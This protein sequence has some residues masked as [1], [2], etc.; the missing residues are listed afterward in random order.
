MKRFSRIM[1]LSSTA[2]AMLSTPAL[3]QTAPATAVDSNEIIVTAQRRSE[4]LL[5]IPL[6]ISATKG[7][8]LVKTGIADITSLRFTTP[9]FMTLSGVGYTQ[10]YIRG[11]GNRILTGADPSVAT[12][13]DDVPRVYGAFVDNLANVE[14]VEV[15]KGAQGGLYGRNATGGV[16]NVIT[17]QPS[18]DGVI[19]EGRVSYGEKKTF[20]ANVFV[21]IPLNE[22]VAL[23]LVGSRES[24]DDYVK[25]VAT[26]NPYQSYAALS[27]SQAA[28]LGDTG[29]R[30]YLLANPNLVTALDK[31]SKVSRL[32][33]LDRWYGAGKLGLQG[34]GFTVTLGGDYSQDSSSNGN[35]W[36]NENPAKTNAVYRSL[37]SSTGNLLFG[38]IAPTGP[39]I[40]PAAYVS[41]QQGKFESVA[42]IEH[43][44]LIK[45]YG[46]SARAD[47]D[48]PA[49]TLSSITA[50][51]W[52]NSEFMGDVGISNV[53]LAGFVS[54]AKRRFAYQELR[55]V[56]TNDGPFIWLGGAT[57]FHEKIDY[58]LTSVV[59]GQSFSPTRSS[60]NTTA[61]S[62]Y[63]QGEYSVTDR[64]KLIASLRYISE[65]KGGSYPAQTVTIFNFAPDMPVA[66]RPMGLVPGVAVP[67]ASVSDKLN[68]L[69]PSATISYGLEDG[70][71]IYLRW[72][73]GL[74][75]GGVNP[76][77]HPAQTLGTVNAFKPEEVDTY[78]AGYKTILFDR[79][80]QL[81]TAI[82]YNDFRN[83]QVTR[84]G[85]TGLSLVMLNAGKAKTYGGEISVDW[86]VSPIFN[87]SAN[88]GYLHARYTDFRFA[89]IPELQVRAFDLSGNTM[90][91]APKWQ[92]SVTANVD[93]PISAN[94]NVAGTL[95]YS[96][97]SKYF[98]TDD[99]NPIVAQK[100]YSLVNA[101]I[102]VHTADQKYGLYLAV[103]NMFNKH[104]AVY[105]T[106]S[107]TS[108][109]IIPGAPRIISGQLEVKF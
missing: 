52:N 65:K 45:D 74:K 89:G 101:R 23:N 109:Y 70:G 48:L 35:G 104:Y 59:L 69:L 91:L 24:H 72:A 64:L 60:T 62:G 37:M 81:S 11:I 51:R 61:F 40:L 54:G 79:K 88:M 46:V 38:S 28:A 83:L 85:Y 94:L 10:I 8:T 58:A 15:L 16:V 93:K 21:N 90:L 29:Q 18:T 19:A 66:G 106:S 43:H 30:A 42:S 34:D 22:N 92:G 99:N 98:T 4:S 95:L 76:L 87:I 102:G 36:Q 41:P 55:L 3:A 44:S 1:S 57:F 2:L 5:D 82:F 71:N 32:N 12:F 27:A 97:M 53:P 25:N 33:N 80:V 78:E 84:A 49:M 107:G 20:N 13:V 31:G 26:A 50:F 75:T 9:G 100:G 96:Y 105:G 39:A 47:V 86:R 67:A 17:R 14:R 56:S 77:V 103:K 6:A 63:A 68:R 108:D 73:R 7:E